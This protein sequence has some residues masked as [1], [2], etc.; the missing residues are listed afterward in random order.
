MNGLAGYSTLL[1]A[2]IVFSLGAVCS[3]A[4]VTPTGDETKAS[5]GTGFHDAA[6][7]NGKADAPLPDS[8]AGS[9]VIDNQSS[10]SHYG[11]E[12]S[13]A[14]WASASTPGYHATDYAVA[15]TS[16]VSD[17]AVFWFELL[18]PRCYDVETWWTEGANRASAL[19]YIAYGHLK[20][21]LGRTTV[22]QTSGGSKWNA[23]GRWTFSKGRNE[24][25]LSRWATSGSF[26]VADAVR[27]TPCNEAAPPEPPAPSG[28]NLSVPYFYQYNNAYEPSATCGVTSTAMA[29]NFW[30]PNNTTPDALYLD[31]GKAKAQSPSGIASIYTAKGIASDWTTTGTRDEIRA[32]LDQGRPV[33]AHGFWT[34]SGHIA[35]I[36]GYDDQG[37]LANDPAGN[38]EICYGCGSGEKVHYAFGAGWDTKLSHDGDIWFSVSDPNGI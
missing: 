35:V 22:D 6:N 3:C 9:F 19:T 17:P 32:H 13:T 11:L 24:I 16:A 21:E 31:F 7:P 25:V 4:V 23:L 33:V 26:A 36:V 12:T 14:W 29:I 34:G 2:V 37:W 10:T 27:L 15:P 28:V 18:Q 20:E 5:D 30:L 8:A 1:R 38:W